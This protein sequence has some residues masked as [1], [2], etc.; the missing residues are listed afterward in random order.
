M[1]TV[2]MISACKR[3]KTFKTSLP[4]KYFT[5]VFYFL[6][7]KLSD[8]QNTRMVTSYTHIS[9]SQ[10]FPRWT[11][12]KPFKLHILAESYSASFCFECG[13]TAKC[14]RIVFHVLACT[15]TMLKADHGKQS[16]SGLEGFL[17]EW[18]SRAHSTS[19]LGSPWD[20]SD[21]RWPGSNRNQP[22]KPQPWNWSS[23]KKHLNNGLV[24]KRSR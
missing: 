4:P 2:Q 19:S 24:L 12:W 6:P 7:S 3:T 8:T 11:W 14:L 22:G 15:S 20:R 13:N 23:E 16:L 5:L 9:S 10:D 21:L 17:T 18:G 1:F